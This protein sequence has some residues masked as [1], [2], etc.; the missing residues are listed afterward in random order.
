MTR[1]VRA[2]W[3]AILLPGLLAAQEQ[4]SLKQRLGQLAVEDVA[5]LVEAGLGEDVV[6]EKPR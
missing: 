3:F 2:A 4:D 6:I 1:F 5:A